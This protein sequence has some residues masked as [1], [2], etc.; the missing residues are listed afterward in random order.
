MIQELLWIH[1]RLGK[2]EC[3]RI[4]L[5]RDNYEVRADKTDLVREYDGCLRIIR[6]NGRV[7]SINPSAVVMI[8]T[9][10]K[11]AYL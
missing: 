10:K 8:S 11:E 7:V 4:I 6:N 5:I 3:M 2:D 1:S 9:V